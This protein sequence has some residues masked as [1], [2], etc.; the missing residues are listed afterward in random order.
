[1]TEHVVTVGKVKLRGKL[2]EDAW[3]DYTWRVDSEFWR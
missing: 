3:D 1:M 2:L